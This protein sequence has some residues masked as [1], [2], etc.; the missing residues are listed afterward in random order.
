MATFNLLSSLT[1][2]GARF[3]VS[4][5]IQQF[6]CSVEETVWRQNLRGS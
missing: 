5:E 6:V 1:D 2:E 4:K 3:R